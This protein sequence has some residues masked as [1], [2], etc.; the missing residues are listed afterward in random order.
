MKNILL[1]LLITGGAAGAIAE[2]A[3]NK[4]ANTAQQAISTKK[5]FKVNGMVCAFCA[6]GIEKKFK[7]QPE[8]QSISVSLETKTVELQF[9]PGKS[10]SDQDV[11]NLLK[12]AG[13]EVVP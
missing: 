11:A 3:T 9:H 12:E 1:A 8:V 2:P 13:Y 7:A 4:A 10:I 6:Q 5:V